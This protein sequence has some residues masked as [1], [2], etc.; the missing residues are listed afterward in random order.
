LQALE[1]DQTYCVSLNQSD[2]L[3]PRRVLRKETVRHPMFTLGRD[4]AQASHLNL[5]RRRG[6]SYCGAYWGFGFH[7]DGV[8]SAV[9]VCDA[10]G[11]ARTF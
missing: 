5:I 7:E 1:T 6:V 11:V 4:A 2:R 3:D 8:R 9:A 10:F